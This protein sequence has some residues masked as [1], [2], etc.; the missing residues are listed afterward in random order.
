[1]QGQLHISVSLGF[2][3]TQRLSRGGNARHFSWLKKPCVSLS[4][5]IS[6]NYGNSFNRLC[7][8]LVWTPESFLHF[9]PCSWKDPSVEVDGVGEVLV[10]GIK[11]F[12]HFS[13][14]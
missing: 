1:M 8:E 14:C 9:F 4:Q 6:R 7:T 2:W 11:K 13:R 12:D 5:V 3:V 10:I